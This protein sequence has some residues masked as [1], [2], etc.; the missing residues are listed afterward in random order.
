MDSNSPFLRGL[1]ES[2]SNVAYE[3]DDIV[4]EQAEHPEL[5]AIAVTDT[6]QAQVDNSVSDPDP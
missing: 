6:K 3:R 2:D 4:E 1:A 5:T